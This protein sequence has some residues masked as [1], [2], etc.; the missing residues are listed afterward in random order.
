M[1]ARGRTLMCA[2]TD[3]ARSAHGRWRVAA[4][5]ALLGVGTLPGAALAIDIVSCGQLVPT[6]EHGYLRANLSCD[7]GVYLGGKATL[8]LN[9]FTLTGNG[10]DMSRGVQC[11]SGER[12]RCTI[13][14]PGEIRGFRSGIECG[15]VRL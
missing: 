6:G 5:V 7:V 15:P 9:G 2:L 1:T 13:N 14:G 4:L 3:K 8:N 11:G 10:S 12:A